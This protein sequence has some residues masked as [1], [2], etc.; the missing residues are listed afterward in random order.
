MPRQHSV[1]GPPHPFLGPPLSSTIRAPNT[2]CQTF[3]ASAYST[4]RPISSAA[5]T[6]TEKKP[7]EKT[8]GEKEREGLPAVTIHG[9]HDAKRLMKAAEW[10]GKQNIKVAS[11]HTLL[12]AG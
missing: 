4:Q 6:I 7:E 1:L 2:R 10:R 8:P 11:S 5:M 3:I 12:P 9:L